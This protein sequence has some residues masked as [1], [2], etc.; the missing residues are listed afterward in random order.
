MMYVRLRGLSMILWPCRLKTVVAVVSW[1]FKKVCTVVCG[2][3]IMV[4]DISGLRGVIVA[5]WEGSM[6]L[7]IGLEGYLVY[8]N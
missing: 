1:W 5:V 3:R 4:V 8:A 7:L 6:W 2:L